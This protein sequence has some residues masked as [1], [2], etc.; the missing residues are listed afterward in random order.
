VQDQRGG[1]DCAL[2]MEEQGHVERGIASTTC[3]RKDGRL[4]VLALVPVDQWTS[5]TMAATWSG[6]S[7]PCV[8]HKK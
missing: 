3:F 7:D 2:I 5:T 1:A 4:A 6:T 8:S